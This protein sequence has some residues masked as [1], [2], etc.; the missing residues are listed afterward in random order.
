MVKIVHLHKRRAGMS[1]EV[2]QD[3][4]ATIA[5]HDPAISVL[6]S[7]VQSHT[8]V[9]GYQKGEMLFDAVEEF[10]FADKN[11]LRAFASS[12][13]PGTMRCARNA[14]VD[15]KLSRAMIVDVYRVKDQPEAADAVKNIEFVNRKPG[16]ELAAFR[17]YWREVH[18]P[19]GSEIPSILRYEQNHLE[20]D[21]YSGTQEPNYDGLAI[22][23]F[24]STAA[25]REGSLSEAYETTR[26]DEVNFLPAGHLPIIVTREVLIR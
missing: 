21:E 16:M 3:A 22:T 18:G 23:W 25:M 2:F 6:V 7:Y 5:T 4:M 9:K 15:A 13:M 1:V 17:R 8:L 11:Q 19:I 20:M 12:E 26:A 24:S 14:L 10:T